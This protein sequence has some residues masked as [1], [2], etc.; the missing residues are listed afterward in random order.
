[1]LE[2]VELGEF[3]EHHP[4]QLSGGMQQ[5]AAI[6]RALALD[7]SLL[8]MDE[9]FGALDEMTR[10]RMNLELLRIWERTGDD[11]RLRDPLDPG[12]GLPL[13]PRRRHDRP[14][15]PDH[16]GHPD[17]PAPHARRRDARDGALLRARHRGSR[18]A[19]RHRGRRRRRRC[20]AGS[21]PRACRREPPPDER[22]RRPGRTDAIGR[23]R[24]R[25]RTV[26][27]WLLPIGI[28]LGALVVWDLLVRVLALPQFI[29]P[30]PSAIANAWVTYLPGALGVHDATRSS[31]S[32]WGSPSVASA[33]WSSGRSPRAGPPCASRCCRSRSRSTRSR[34]SPSRRS[35]TTGSA[36]TARSR[37]RS[38]RRCSVFFPVMINT[39]RGLLHVEPAAARAHALARRVR[40]ADVP[41]GPRP[42]ALPFI[43]TA[44]KV[45]TTL[46]TI[47]AV[48]GE[49]FGA[50]SIS[51]GPVHR[52]RTPPTSTSSGRGR[53]S[54]SPRRS[55]SR[56]TSWSSS[57]SG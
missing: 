41:G 38:S 29:L 40:H 30:A 42:S 6:A 51:L 16:Q 7:P 4:W 31:R 24:R 36:S 33:A 26:R 47:G 53:P 13:D 56:S 25:G 45:A 18:G 15:G 11:D 48:I 21:P 57:P 37:R 52:P 49:Y 35:S 32:C 44:L 28:F 14:A 34:S 5:R 23:R 50:P 20:A 55:G 19:A 46:A 12:G 43:F 1:M 17:R 8:L 22:R 54:R 27:S 10:E 39:A 9:P 3:G 2:L